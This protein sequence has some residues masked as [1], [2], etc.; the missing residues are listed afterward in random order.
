MAKNL[1]SEKSKT[2]LLSPAYRFVV[3]SLLQNESFFQL[4]DL[5]NQIKDAEGFPPDIGNYPF[6]ILTVLGSDKDHNRK[7]YSDWLIHYFKNYEKPQ[8]SIVDLWQ[9]LEHMKISIDTLPGIYIWPRKY[10]IHSK[11]NLAM[12]VLIIHVDGKTEVLENFAVVASSNIFVF[13]E[14][15]KVIL[16]Q[17]GLD[18]FTALLHFIKYNTIQY[19]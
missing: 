5:I 1:E 13:R 11:D 6:G 7:I 12:V 19:N 3:P 15:E 9:E 14:R 17:I 18:T 8:N 4:H 10:V 2:N 16:L